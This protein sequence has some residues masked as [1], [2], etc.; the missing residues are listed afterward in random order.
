[1][2]KQSDAFAEYVWKYQSQHGHCNGV[3]GI[4]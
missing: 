3:D 1:M 4:N 2:I